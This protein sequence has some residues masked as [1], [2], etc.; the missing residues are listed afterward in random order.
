M[1]LYTNAE[2]LV[3]EKTKDLFDNEIL[4]SF[5]DS[6]GKEWVSNNYFKLL[7]DRDRT[8]ITKLQPSGYERYQKEKTEFDYSYL[9]IFGELSS[10]YFFNSL[11]H[12]YDFFNFC[13]F[14]IENI[15]REDSFYKVKAQV[16]DWYI[17]DFKYKYTTGD[18]INLKISIDGDYLFIYLDDVI[19]ATYV[20]VDSNTLTELEAFMKTEKCNYSKVTWPRHADGSCDYDGSK[21]AVTAQTAKATSSTNVS[22]NKTM[23]VSENL[24]L[25]SGEATTSEFITVMSAG[26]KVKI[27]ALGKAENID[28]IN[29]NW[30]K[31]EVLSGAKNR[32]GRAIRAGTE[33]WCYGGY[34]A[35]TTEANK[36]EYTDTKEISDIKIEEAPKQEINI[37]IVCSIIGAVLLLLLVIL[38]FAVRKKKDNP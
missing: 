31:V 13:S 18:F 17:E 9:E 29:S 19:L 26:T 14:Y 16:C 32:D 33:G 34:L 5:Q 3:P 30:V 25:R 27:L 35:E 22:P 20:L 7:K 28:G 21:K 10:S 8:L 11:I 2:M 36:F 37:G 6:Q 1:P 38:I 23:L 15:E 4:T 24:K 12:F